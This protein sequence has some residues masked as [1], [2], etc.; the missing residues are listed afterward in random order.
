MGV[1]VHQIFLEKL[2]L[3]GWRHRCDVTVILLKNEV[4]SDS[5]LCI[6]L[7]LILNQKMHKLS[8]LHHKKCLKMSSTGQKM[9]RFQKVTSKNLKNW[10][11]F[12]YLSNLKLESYF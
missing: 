11:T 10:Q 7:F 5:I 4:T 1:G 9:L 12:R 2:V 3:S 8:W 6:S